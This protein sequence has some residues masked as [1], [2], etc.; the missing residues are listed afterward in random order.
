MKDYKHCTTRV[1]VRE[2]SWWESLAAGVG[3]VGCLVA[4]FSV[5]ALITEA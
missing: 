2:E 4:A 5:L 1:V 3:F